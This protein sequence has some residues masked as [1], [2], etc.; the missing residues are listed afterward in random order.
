M[1]TGFYLSLFL[2]VTLYGGQTPVKGETSVTLS[3]IQDGNFPPYM[4]VADGKPLGLYADIVREL[5]TRLPDIKVSLEAAPWNRAKYLVSSGRRAGLVGTYYRP[6]DRPYLT[7]YSIPIWTE[8]TAVFC[9][10]GIAEPDWSFPSDYAGLRFGNNEGFKSPGAAFFAM[11][12]AGQISLEEASLPDNLRKLENSRIDCYVQDVAVTE[13]E[14]AKAGYSNIERITVL[15]SEPV[16]IG[17]TGRSPSGPTDAFT[18]ILDRE[19]TRMWDDGTIESIA[20]RYFPPKAPEP[21]PR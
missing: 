5:D 6:R 10:K 4:Y 19:L 11:V 20:E 12:D 2:I 8:E 1:K 15:T 14:I 21:D 13:A 9:R 3:L 16:H 7:A 18:Q 17:F